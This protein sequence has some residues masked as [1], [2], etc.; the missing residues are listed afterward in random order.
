[1]CWIVDLPINMEVSDLQNKF[2]MFLKIMIEGVFLFKKK[3]RW[4]LF[5]SEQDPDYQDCHISMLYNV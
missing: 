3:I 1:M 2:L 4:S 5:T